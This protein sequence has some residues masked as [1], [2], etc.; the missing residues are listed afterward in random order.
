MATAGPNYSTTWSSFASTPYDDDD[1]VNVANLASTSTLATITASTYD[2]NDYSYVALGTGFALSLPAGATVGGITVEINGR[3]DAG[4][5]SIAYVQLQYDGAAY[6]TAKTTEQA[7]TS[8]LATY[9]FGG[10]TDLW[11]ASPTESIVEATSFGVRFAVKAT[12]PNTDISFDWA[13]ITVTYLVYKQGAVTTEAVSSVTATPSVSH[14]TKQGAVT[15]EATSLVRA[16]VPW[17][18]ETFTTTGDWSYSGCTLDT[19]SEHVRPARPI[20][21]PDSGAQ[22]V[23]CTIAASTTGAIWRTLPAAKDLSADGLVVEVW[24]YVH[25]ATYGTFSRY[26]EMRLGADS[27]NY[28]YVNTFLNCNPGWNVVRWPT[29]GDCWTS[30]GSPS[31]SN[32]QYIRM[33]FNFS[34]VPSEGGKVT[35]VS[36]RVGGT[37]RRATF[38]QTFDDGYSS[39]YNTAKAICDARSVKATCYLSPHQLPGS[40]TGNG[41]MTWAQIEALVADGWYMGHHGDNHEDLTTKTYDEVQAIIKDAHDTLD[42][43]ASGHGHHGAYPYV[44]YNDTVVRA[45]DDLSGSY[46]Q[47]TQR[48]GGS[49]ATD[50]EE[51]HWRMQPIQGY[52]DQ[53]ADTLANWKARIDRVCATQDTLLALCHNLGVTMDTQLFTDIL[54]YVVAKGMWTPNVDTWFK[55]WSASRL[56]NEATGGVT[57]TPS[58][59]HAHTGAL[60]SEGVSD[61][62]ATPALA[63][64]TQQGAVTSEATSAATATPSVEGAQAKQG[65]V[66]TEATSSVTASSSVAHMTAQGGSTSE[67]TSAVT[68]AASVS[69]PTAQGASTS[70]AASSVTTN[71][72]VAH[73]TAQGALLDEATSS[74]TAVAAIGHVT[75]QGALTSETVSAVTATPSVEEAS[76]MTA[77][78]DYVKLVV[79]WIQPARGASTSEGSSDVTAAPAVAHATQQGT[80]TGEATSDITASAS[81]SH[82]TAQGAFTDEATS[83]VTAIGTRVAC[84]A[85]TSEALSDVVCLPSAAHVTAQGALLDEAVSSVVATPGVYHYQSGALSSEALSSVTAAP[86]VAAG[87]T[88]Q[89]TTEATSAVTASASVTHATQEGATTTEATSFVTAVPAVAH[90]TAQGASTSEALSSVTA[91]A[92]VD[93]SRAGALSS[94]AASSVTAAASVAHATQQGALSSEAT[95]V[96]TATPFVLPSVTSKGYYI[97]ATVE[98]PW[99]AACACAWRA[100]VDADWS[101]A[102]ACAWQT[103]TLVSGWEVKL[104]VSSISHLS[105]QYVYGIVDAPYSPTGFVVKMAFTA[106]GVEPV[107]GDWKDATWDGTY[108]GPAGSYRCRIVVGPGATPTLAE[109][110]YDV[111][112]QVTATNETPVCMAGRLVVT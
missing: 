7:I 112:V 90:A 62:T 4:S 51:A 53:E 85:M 83:H 41:Q 106:V 76:V 37:G 10:S 21:E 42:P 89:V 49:N 108:V 48:T 78:V 54:D 77:S 103:A 36:V 65:A 67:A 52:V 66:T 80:L 30:T 111:W 50:P 74:V 6:G 14:A 26:L 91:T 40:G 29:Q 13:R 16:N 24:L 99:H 68:V 93:H 34:T 28:Y 35:W 79:E 107:T 100:N 94:E 61:V 82:T 71:A 25:A 43:H 22:H 46:T 32:V 11:G 84:G 60:T 87:K 23:R 33:G 55:S 20:A 102:C 38:L 15:T 95:T 2:N 63:H 8:S 27:S 19:D 39:Q 12:S 97:T 45:I 59:D 58:V 104:T 105:K 75:A 88:G 9:T 18:L 110:A 96:V 92:S 44:Y 109:G 56:R 5:A 3:Y 81:V 31:W 17:L 98:V 69:H 101:S 73:A 86:T 47:Y 1:W 70:E 72:S 57:A 64:A